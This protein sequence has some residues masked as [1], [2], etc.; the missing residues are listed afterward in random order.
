MIL[1]SINRPCRLLLATLQ[2]TVTMSLTCDAEGEYSPKDAEGRD[3]LYKNGL[4]ENWFS[5]RE[6]VFAKSY[7]LENSLWESIFREDQF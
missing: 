3:E 2:E 7:S 5:V 6:E 4:P 1:E